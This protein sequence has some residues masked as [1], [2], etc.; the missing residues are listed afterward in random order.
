M[1]AAHFAAGHQARVI[2]GS[3]TLSGAMT[4]WLENLTQEEL[5]NLD[6]DEN[7]DPV[8]PA[9]PSPALTTESGYTEHEWQVFGLCLNTESAQERTGKRYTILDFNESQQMGEESPGECV[10]RSLFVVRNSGFKVWKLWRG[11]RT[12]F[13]KN[14]RRISQHPR[15]PRMVMDITQAWLAFPE[16]FEPGSNGNP[17]R[18]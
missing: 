14:G 2:R 9:P 12:L 18:I 16:F 4:E 1:Q 3:G 6:W 17:R 10:Q 11:V 8:P 15:R 7:G 13:T 5:D